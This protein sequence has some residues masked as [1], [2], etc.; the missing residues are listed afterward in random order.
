MIRL[1]GDHLGELERELGQLLLTA[2]CTGDDNFK[3]T[4]AAALKDADELFHR[5]KALDAFFRW[6]HTL[7]TEVR[8][9][10]T[11]GEI[12]E[13]FITYLGRD[14]LSGSQWKRIKEEFALQGTTRGRPGPRG[15]MRKRKLGD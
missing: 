15:K 14:E 7:A 9:A 5:G 12:K 4:L 11:I 2:V 3:D 10:M 1:F 6:K 8:E 13:A